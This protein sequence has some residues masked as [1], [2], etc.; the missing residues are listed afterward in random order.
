[1]AG[2]LVPVADRGGPAADGAGLAAAIGEPG[3][4]GGD[5]ADVRRQGCGAAEAHQAAKSRQSAA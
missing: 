5:D 4:I 1:M 2:Q 3:E